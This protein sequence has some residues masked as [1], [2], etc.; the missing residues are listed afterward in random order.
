MSSQRAT[1]FDPVWRPLCLKLDKLAPRFLLPAGS[2]DVLY[3]PSEFYQALRTKILSARRHVFIST[4]YIGKEEHELIETLQTALRATPTLRLSITTDALRGTREAPKT[5]C[6]SLL[7]PLVEE[8]GQER[9]AITM[10]HTPRLHGLRKRLI[11]RRFDEGWGLQH[12]K[13]YG[14]DDEVMLSGANLSND[15]FTNRQDRYHVFRNASLASYYRRVHDAVASLSYR[16]VPQE[17]APAG[18]S[19]CWAD[20][21]I[22][23]PTRQPRAFR[24]YAES[25]VGSLGRPGAMQA[26]DFTD[27]D[28]AATIVYPLIQMTPLLERGGS[29]E[30]PAVNAVLDALATAAHRS[31]RWLFTAG[32]FNVFEDYRSRLLHALG[33]GTVVTASPDANGFYMSRGPSGMLA[34]AYTLLARQYLAEAERKRAQTSFRML[35]WTH[36]RYGESGR[37]TYHA[38]GLWIEPAGANAGGDVANE[39]PSPGATGPSLTFIGSSN[40]TRRS[41]RLDLEATALVLTADPGLR[42]ALAKETRHLTEH[43][44]QV[45]VEDLSTPERRADLKT[46]IALWL[47]QGML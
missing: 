14:F 5:C 15:Y 19:L 33:H 11:P 20:D 44:D 23:E 10:F 40:F 28:P 18:L 42:A 6:A 25:I 41:Q 32:Y 3:E 34:A 7:A 29:T 9:V 17:E 22:P 39:H 46:R 2:V 26:C 16:V 1:G 4:L 36:G 43:A 37:W 35:E 12:M 31:S 8:F 45:T 47:C 21:R 30:Q 24:A 27:E 38:K 13:I